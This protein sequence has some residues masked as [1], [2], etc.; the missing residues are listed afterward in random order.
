MLLGESAD[1]PV[2]L[3]QRTAGWPAAAGAQVTFCFPALRLR[4][5]MLAQRGSLVVFVFSLL[6]I[7][8]KMSSRALLCEL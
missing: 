4:L 3:S 5:C 1:T 8:Y 2:R 6:T 7:V